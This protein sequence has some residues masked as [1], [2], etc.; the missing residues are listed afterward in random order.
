MSHAFRPG[1]DS[2]GFIFQSRRI[3]EAVTVD[4][5]GFHVLHLFTAT[6]RVV[7]SLRDAANWLE[8]I[9]RAVAAP[10]AMA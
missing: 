10:L 4:N 8:N 2:I 5:D 3:G 6:G 9:E 7:A 1:P